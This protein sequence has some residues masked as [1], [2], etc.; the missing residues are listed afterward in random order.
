MKRPNCPSREGHM[1]LLMA[2]IWPASM[3]GFDMGKKT[4]FGPKAYFYLLRDEKQK[5]AY[6]EG[7]KM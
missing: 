2:A 7:P 5:T 1:V 3:R 6:Y 4:I